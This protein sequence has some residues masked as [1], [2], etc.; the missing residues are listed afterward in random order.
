MV[1]AVWTPLSSGRSSGGTNSIVFQ[2][3]GELYAHWS[4]RESNTKSN[5]LQM[6]ESKPDALKR[7]EAYERGVAYPDCS[8]RVDRRR[9]FIHFGPFGKGQLFRLGTST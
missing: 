1:G 5:Q 4:F 3:V 2:W 8:P 6:M 9:V 7:S